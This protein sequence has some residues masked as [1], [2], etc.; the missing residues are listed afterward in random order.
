MPDI[1]PIAQIVGVIATEI[2]TDD[3]FPGTY[4]FAVSLSTDPGTEWFIELSAVY[5]AIVYPGK[6]PIRFEGN[7]LR[8]FYLPRYADDLPRYLRFLLRVVADANASVE[9][10]NRVVPDEEQQ[11]VAF[12]EKL[13]AAAA[14]VVGR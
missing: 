8:I 14:D 7:K 5:D 4:G 2:E 13:R 6:P 3:S 9:R 11:K 12:L 1:I 10:R